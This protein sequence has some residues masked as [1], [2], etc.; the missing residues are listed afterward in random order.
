[1]PLGKLINKRWTEMLRW[2]IHAAAYL[3]KNIFMMKVLAHPMVEKSL[4]ECM[5]RMI[6]DVGERAQADVDLDA[7]KNKLREFG[8]D[9]AMKTI[10]SRTPD[11]SCL[12]FVFNNLGL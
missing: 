3:I 11:I 12:R 4:Y 6:L 7:Y 10:G 8:T 5:A 1:M 9:L 2:L